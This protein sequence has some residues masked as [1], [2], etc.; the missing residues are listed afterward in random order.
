[1]ANYSTLKD[2]IRDVIKT[3]GS[4]AI[5]GSLLQQALLSMIDSLGV[6][7]QFAGYATPL[8]PIPP[9]SPDQR[10][11]YLAFDAGTYQYFGGTEI[12]PGQVGIFIFLNGQW[13]YNVRTIANLVNNLYAGGSDKFLSA[14]MG[15]TLNEKFEELRGETVGP[16]H[17]WQVTPD[18][19]VWNFE[20]S[21]GKTYRITPIPNV[22]NTSSLPSSNY[23]FVL[24]KIVGGVSTNI[25]KVKVGESVAEHYDIT[26]ES[27]DYYQ[28]NVMGDTGQSVTVNVD[29]Q[30]GY[31]EEIAELQTDVAE[32]Q[33]YVFGQNH[34]WQLIGQT[35]QT[36]NFYT[37]V[38]KKYRIT[39]IPNVWNLSTIGSGVAYFVINKVLGGTTTNIV[40]VRIGS[41]VA[42]YYE[43]VAEE[44]DYYFINII[45]DAGQTVKVNVSEIKDVVPKTINKK[46]ACFGD[47]ITSNDV[48]GI[49]TK[50]NELLETELIGNFA[51]GGASCSD[52][53]YNGQDYSDF[54]VAEYHNAI[55]PENVLK[56]QVLRLLQHV[57]P[58]GEQI[59]W[60]H[61]IDGAFNVPTTVGVGLGHTTDIPDI[62]YIAIGINDGQIDGRQGAPWT[63]DGITP[64]PVVDDFETVRQQS[65]SQLTKMSIASAL[66]WS[67]ETLQSK[68]PNA[69]IFVASPL[70]AGYVN[71]GSMASFSDYYTLTKAQIIKKVANLCSVLYV[72]SFERSGYGELIAHQYG[73]HPSG[74]WLNINIP[75]FVAKEIDEQYIER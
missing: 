75:K 54:S 45:G 49:G 72:P 1:M 55:R 19:N 10:I 23:Y 42:P 33:N 63:T 9:E 65:Y 29:L 17:T 67:I 13:N 15:K 38:G 28:L 46:F 59:T 50:V 58:L 70:H 18:I 60:T 21:A 22:W 16:T 8:S 32:L 62:I 3:N 39:P 14:E 26:A 27:V 35:N 68:F 41:N 24:N 31:D 11:F 7:Y 69:Q 64:T 43:I 47:S 73:L 61:P 52:W 34:T 57:T 66:R 30:T 74:V 4:N 37:E 25:F 6:G 56:N 71:S 5:T 20:L 51:V 2:A 53:S 40:V 44:A 36:W 48:S 12:S